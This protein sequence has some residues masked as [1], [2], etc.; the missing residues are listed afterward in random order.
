MDW[1]RNY[2]HE[3]EMDLKI[4]SGE[5]VALEVKLSQQAVSASQKGEIGVSFAIQKI[6]LAAIRAECFSFLIKQHK[7]AP[8]MDFKHWTVP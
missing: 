4:Y 3:Q 2:R 8:K 6:I 1:D 5:K 7:D